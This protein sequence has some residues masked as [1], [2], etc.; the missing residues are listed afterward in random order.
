MRHSPSAKVGYV[1]KRYPRFSETF[2]INEILAHEAAG[3][4]VEIFALGFPYQPYF[5]DA[6]AKV[7]APVRYLCADGLKAI[8][9]WAALEQ[10]SDAPSPRGRRSWNS[11]ARRAA[12]ERMKKYW[13]ARKQAAD[14]SAAAPTA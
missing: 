10:G 1:V 11:A 6:I 9:F 2:I 7:R 4:E 8:D 14:E 13:A 3:L 5:Q 12:A